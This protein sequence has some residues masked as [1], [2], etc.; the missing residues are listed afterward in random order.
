MKFFSI[1]KY[2][3]F[4]LFITFSHGDNFIKKKRFLATN[5][6]SYIYLKDTFK[7]KFKIGS[8]AEALELDKA[9]EFIKNN[10]DIITPSFE[11]EPEII[12]DQENSKLIGE[13]I[14]VQINFGTITRK[15]LQF[16][17]KNEIPIKGH[18]FVWNSLTPTSLFKENFDYEAKLVTKEIMDKRLENFIRNVFS[19][20]EKEFPKL[21]IYAYDVVSEIFLN[22]GGGLRKESDSYWVKIYGDDS[23]IIKAFSY[24]RKYAPKDCKLILSDYNEFI[25]EKTNDIY[26][27]AMKLK[28]LDLI[29]GIGMESHLT[30][31][32]PTFEDYKTAFEKFVSTGLEIFITELEI[33]SYDNNIDKQ[34][35]FY[36]ELFELFMENKDSIGLISLFATNDGFNGNRQCNSLLFDYFYRPKKVYFCALDAIDN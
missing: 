3:I 18:C 14:N 26:N 28:E 22:D 2:F 15:I 19:I 9:E 25:P 13:N 17:E 36:K 23:F 27:I 5:E 33:L 7:E 11:L 24:A 12:I 31:E 20:L 8:L 35:N 21:K 1:F 34:C 4:I 6:E 30:D 10:F 29:D 16:C 32:F